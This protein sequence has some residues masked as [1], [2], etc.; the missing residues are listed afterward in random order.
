MIAAMFSFTYDLLT[1]EKFDI[2][3]EIFRCGEKFSG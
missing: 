2:P 1:D 3:E